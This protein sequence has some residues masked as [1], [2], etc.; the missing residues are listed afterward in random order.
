MESD[1]YHKIICEYN[2]IGGGNLGLT[3]TV[4]DPLVDKEII[5]KIKFAR[6]K[7]NINKIDFIANSYLSW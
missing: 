1:L 5:S 6:G 2:E 4:G 3:P 7:K